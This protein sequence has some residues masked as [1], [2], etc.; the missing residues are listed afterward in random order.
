MTTDDVTFETETRATAGFVG[1]TWET[2]ELRRTIA[3]TRE[4]VAVLGLSPAD[5]KTVNRSLDAA[6]G[7]AAAERPDRYSVG[8]HLEDAAHALKDV[9]ALDAVS[10]A[11]HRAT[12]LLGPAGLATVATAL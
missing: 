2:V 10:Q 12:E 11:L 6:S 7:E 9:G 4:A 8:E 1:P 5:A 3:R